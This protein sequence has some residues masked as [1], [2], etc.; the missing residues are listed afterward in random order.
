MKNSLF[1][2]L[3]LIGLTANAQS[4]FDTADNFFK[5]HVTAGKVDYTGLKA[6]S[7]TLNKLCNQIENYAL[8]GKDKNTQLAFY[9][10]AYNVLA[11]KNVLDN[12]SLNSPLDVDGFFDKLKF[13]VA[14][15]S[16]TLNN[17]ENDIIRPQF[18][19]ARIHFVLVCVA[20]GCPKIASSAYKPSLLERQLEAATRKAINN[21]SFIYQK[22]ETLYLS[23]IFK[24]YKSD[25]ADNDAGL[26]AYVN[27]YLNTPVNANTK[28]DYYSYDWS[29]NKQ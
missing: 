3:F 6:N 19:D 1:V 20:N 13:N 10:N 25:F 7:A 21:P 15:R 23:E 28:V 16:L 11:I 4:F 14:G 29:L 26:V 12:W 9:I 2:L 27:K 8:A 22:G 18:N 5:K 17:I 24:W